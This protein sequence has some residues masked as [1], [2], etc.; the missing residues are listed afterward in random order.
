MVDC[1]MALT[2]PYTIEL[3]KKAEPYNVKWF[4]EFLPPDS[5]EGYKQVKEKVHGT[6]V[7][8]GE[9]EYT[10]YGFKL[11]LENNCADVLQPDVTWV[12]GIT[13]CRRIIALASA[14]DIPIIPHGSSVYSYHLQYAFANC[15]VAEFLVL[16]PQGDQIVPFF[17]NVF[18]DEPLPKDGF[19]DLDPKKP[20]FGVTLNKGGLNLRRPYSHKPVTQ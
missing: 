10:R 5:Y 17:G 7:T 3:I 6:L 18:T 1:Y 8:T 2:V 13:E 9:H 16:S 20:G 15:P 11:L 4:E 12:G 14:Y 19:I